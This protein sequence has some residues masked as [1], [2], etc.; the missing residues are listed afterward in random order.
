MNS[1][2]YPTSQ[3]L[4]QPVV[5]NYSQYQQPQVQHFIGV[6]S[7]PSSQT[8]QSQQSVDPNSLYYQNQAVYQQQNYDNNALDYEQYQ[9]IQDYH[10]M[11]FNYNDNS[12]NMPSSSLGA[13]KK[14]VLPVRGDVKVI[15]YA[16]PQNNWHKVEPKAPDF[17]PGWLTLPN[18]TVEVEF[19]F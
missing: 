15:G 9:P 13:R 4:Q 6:T 2:Q 7:I 18:T 8:Q 5:A 16:P 14:V 19:H 3:Q 1:Y 11:P 12:A 10:N 17:L